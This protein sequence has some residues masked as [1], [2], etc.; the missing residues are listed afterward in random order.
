MEFGAYATGGDHFT[1]RIK[2]GSAVPVGDIEL[3]FVGRDGKPP[4]AIRKGIC[5]YDWDFSAFHLASLDPGEGIDV[6]VLVPRQTPME[7]TLT[8]TPEGGEPLT[9]KET[10]E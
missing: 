9:L 3:K 2:N 4:R 5:G 6:I 7:C 1:L 8:F 10:L